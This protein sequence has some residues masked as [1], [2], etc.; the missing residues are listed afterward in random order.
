MGAGTTVFGTDALLYE[1]QFALMVILHYTMSTLTLIRMG[2]YAA[3]RCSAVFST[4]ALSGP[5]ICALSWVPGWCVLPLTA[6]VKWWYALVDKSYCGIEAPLLSLWP[7]R[8]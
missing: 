7:P 6:I 1:L 4:Y 8:S 3:T 5:A 2:L